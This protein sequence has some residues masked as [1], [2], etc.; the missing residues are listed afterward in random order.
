TGNTNEASGKPPKKG[1]VDILNDPK[2]ERAGKQMPDGDNKGAPSNESKPGDTKKGVSGFNP[3]A[4]AANELPI[5]RS[6]VKK[7]EVKDSAPLYRLA[8][9]TYGNGQLGARA[10]E[11]NKPD[12]SK[13]LKT[14]QQL[15]L[16]P[17]EVLLGQARLPR[18][19]EEIPTD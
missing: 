5:T 12:P 10:A 13:P 2:A 3:T 14:T 19:D 18:P 9:A 11:S 16:P 6:S 1:P 17:K 15:T 7:Y 8:S 4:I